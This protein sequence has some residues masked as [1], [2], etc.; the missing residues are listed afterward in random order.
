VT[1]GAV[2]VIDA[3][4]VFVCKMVLLATTGPPVH[5]EQLAALA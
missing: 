2:K 3:T 5:E 4:A 1:A